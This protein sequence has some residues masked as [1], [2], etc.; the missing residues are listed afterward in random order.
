MIDLLSL[1]S[2]LRA[3]FHTT[4]AISQQ[5][6]SHF[7][8]PTYPDL[9]SCASETLEYS[10]ENATAVANSCCSVVKGGLVLQTQFWSTWKRRVNCCPRAAG[11][12][13]ACG[14]IIVMG[15][16]FDS[17]CDLSRQ[18][19][20]TPSPV[21]LR[22]GT[23]VTLPSERG[24]S[25][26]PMICLQQPVSPARTQR[27]IPCPRSRVRLLLRQEPSHTWAVLR[28]GLLS[29]RSGI[30]TTSKEP[31]NMVTSK[32]SILPPGRLAALRCLFITTSVSL[33]L[34]VL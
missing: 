17:Y 16:S 18:Y 10:C 9:T 34:S 22:N 8:S 26:R 13:M 23:V 6:S 20:P 19:D 33:L 28:M 7:I 32:L 3:V 5:P 25:I 1:A 30:S 15:R 12:Y 2:L 21:T 11:L 29:P 27:P 4:A 31:S 24:R 14:L